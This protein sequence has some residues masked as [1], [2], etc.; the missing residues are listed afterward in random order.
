MDEQDTTTN[1]SISGIGGILGH[2]T[3]LLRFRYR[4]L[5]AIPL[6]T[7]PSLIDTLIKLNRRAGET[8]PALDGLSNTY[9]IDGQ[10]ATGE[11]FLFGANKK[12]AM[13]SGARDALMAYM[14]GKD[15]EDTLKALFEDILD[16]DKTGTD[17]G[18]GPVERAMARSADGGDL[19]G[20]SL[21]D[22]EQWSISWTNFADVYQNALPK[23][24]QW[25]ET[26]T[27][28]PE[29]AQ[30]A[31]ENFWPTVSEYSL[32]YNLLLAAKVNADR[33]DS[34]RA[35]FAG[36]FDDSMEALYQEGRLYVIELSIFQQVQVNEVSGFERFTPATVT[37]LEQDPQTKALTPLAVRV[38]GQNDSGVQIFVRGQATDGA[39]IYALQAAKTSLTVWG[40]WFG[41]VYHWHIVTAA[42]QKTMFENIP[43]GHPLYQLLAPQSDY[44]IPFDNI[45][46]L[47]W[48]F[49]APPTSVSSAFQFLDLANTFARGR[50]YFDDDPPNTLERLGIDEQDFTE[51]GQTPWNQY[52]I[53]GYLLELWKATEA[54]VKVFVD[55]TYSN[56]NA[57]ADDEP[58]Q[59]W[60]AAASSRRDGNIRGLPTMD[61]REALQQVLTSMIFRITTHGNSRLN[62][63]AN[64]ALTFVANFP[65]CLQNSTIPTPDA[66]ITTEELLTYL[67]KTGTIG[68]MVTFYFT[69]VFSVP[70]VP[71]IP[72]TG[73]ES[74]LF[75]PGGLGDPR[76]KALVAYRNAVVRLITELEAEAPQVHQW[77]L[78]IET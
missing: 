43:E 13:E 62:S 32:A 69:F 70:Y 36:S 38:S 63:A 72:L 75:F 20:L 74:D 4:N 59:D 21:D 26:V 76:N 29:G 44:L 71:F 3:Q 46:L 77:P 6:A 14:E 28:S 16:E 30:A 64:P 56:D 24:P 10:T 54:Y 67:P 2:L 12:S 7:I 41:H 52:R 5:P 18:G 22:P 47:L 17:Q 61:T 23:L 27:V 73:V 39:W 35:A 50:R 49:V 55:T 65:P 48:R 78:N 33:I 1:S 40:I 58:L 66:D 60:I 11:E 25:A 51:D 42:M 9:T 68:G 19:T 37:L 31:T 15:G 34:V 45:L 8:E 53:T 57:V